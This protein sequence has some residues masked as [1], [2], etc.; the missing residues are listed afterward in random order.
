[1]SIWIVDDEENLAAGLK[2]AFEKRGYTAR[3][4]PTLGELQEALNAEI[5]SLVFLDQCLPDGN[6]LDMLPV[7]IKTAPRCRVVLMTAYG[8]S[9]LVV[10]AIRQ[11]AYNYLDKPFPLDAVLNMM[12]RAFESIRLQN[13]AE[14]QMADETNMLLGASP[15]MEKLSESLLKLAPYQDITVLLTGESGTGK[16]VAARM[17]HRASKCPGEFVAVNCSAIPEALLEEELF[18]YTKGAYTGA[19]SNKPGLIEVADKGTLFL[20][21]I[22]DLPLQL[23]AKLFRFIDQR[24]VRPLGSTKEKK[25]SLKL[26]CA[27][28]LDLDKKVKEESFRKDLFFRISVIPLRLPPLRERGRDVLELAAFFLGDFSKK[29]NKAAP[30]LTE[31][32]EEAFLSYGW[33]G[34]VR[35]LRNIIERI[36]ILGASPDGY[37]RLCDL[38]AEMLETKGPDAAQSAAALKTGVSL[39]EMLD[40]IEKDSVVK[41]LAESGGNRTQAAAALGITRFSLIRR[42]QK[43]GLDQA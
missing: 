22:G 28:C 30:R 7:I 8:D 20:D 38:P 9:S 13:Q 10:K 33:P 19:D 2:R 12:T 6:G 27:T 18:G 39:S 32:V 35:E 34:N 40:S 21:E 37:I 26:I 16:E 11:G 36:L 4:I 25:I 43:H 31:E 23:Q 17:I 14:M 41:A 15:A 24:T 42:M 5:P 29:M 3:C 1:M